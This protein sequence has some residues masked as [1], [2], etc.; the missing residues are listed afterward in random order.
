MA[1]DIHLDNQPLPKEKLYVL[2]LAAIQFSHIVDF[3]VL[4]PLGPMLMRELNISPIQFGT[5]VSSYN[6]SAAIFGVIYGLIADS[7]DRKK[8]LLI[9]FIGFILGT[10]YCGF[11]E[12]YETL[13]IGR[14]FAGAFGGILTSVVMAMVTDLIPFQRRGRALGTVMSSF[15]IASVLGVPLGLIIANNYGWQNTFIFI[16]GISVFVFIA[17]AIIFPNLKDHICPSSKKETLIR[18]GK[19]LIKPD[20]AKSYLLI[21]LN[22]LSAFMLIPFL[23]P[24]AVKN[25]GILETEL[26]YLYLVGGFFTIITARIIGKSTDHNGAFKTFLTVNL[27][28]CIPIY[29]YTNTGPLELGVFLAISALFMTT[30]SGR[31]IPIMSLVS[32]ISSAKDRGTFMGLINSVRGLSS[33]VATLVAGMIISENADGTLSG[34]N[35]VGYLSIIFSIGI[36]FLAKHVHNIALRNKNDN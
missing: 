36:L 27:L 10:L 16:A 18:L 34:F 12:S 30:V 6:F 7:Y 29:M 8:I 11:A 24:V 5:L 14:I 13:I 19:I 22:V 35:H 2:L 28:S 15:S 4:M 1:T 23:S 17:A 25:L 21:F 26:K 31:F 3:V 32:E 33:A 9:C 20:Y